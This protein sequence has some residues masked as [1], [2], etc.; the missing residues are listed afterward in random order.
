MG[1]TLA[2]GIPYPDPTARP[3]DG[4][5]AM[6]ALAERMQTWLLLWQETY[7]RA[8]RRPAAEVQ[9]IPAVAG[10]FQT[11]SPTGQ[12]RPYF[13]TVGLDTANMVDLGKRADRIVFTRPGCYYLQFKAQGN[14]LTTCPFRITFWGS[15]KTNGGGT[16]TPYTATSSGFA[17][18]GSN[19]PA[20]SVGLLAR[21]IEFDL[22]ER[23]VYADVTMLSGGNPSCQVTWAQFSAFWVS[24][25]F[26]F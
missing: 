14:S 20:V 15:D 13:N 9:Y 16:N 19:L 7:A 2:Y 22:E 3:C 23:E 17:G 21:C 25:D 6:K 18:Q 8:E 26:S 10:T 12:S 24:D 1:K 5:E 11:L 4:D